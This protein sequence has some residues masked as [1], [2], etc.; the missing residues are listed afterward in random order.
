M[1]KILITLATMAVV[2]IADLEEC[3]M[4]CIPSYQKCLMIKQDVPYC[5]D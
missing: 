3:Q 4:S 2:A 5:I 1:R